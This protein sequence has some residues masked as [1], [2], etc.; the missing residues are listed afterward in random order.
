MSWYIGMDGV[1]HDFDGNAPVEDD[2]SGE[3]ESGQAAK[4][5]HP[6]TESQGVGR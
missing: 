3:L 2:T 1:V 4:A 6:A 5:V